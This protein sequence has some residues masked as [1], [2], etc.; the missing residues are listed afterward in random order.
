MRDLVVTVSTLQLNLLEPNMGP[1]FFY[2]MTKKINRKMRRAHPIPCA[3]LIWKYRRESLS[4][5]SLIAIEFW[6]AE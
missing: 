5:G 3:R 2:E 4:N 1:M 6:H